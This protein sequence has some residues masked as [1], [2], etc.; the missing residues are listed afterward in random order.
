MLNQVQR[1]EGL[2]QTAK[3]TVSI[4]LYLKSDNEQYPTVLYTFLGVVLSR[5]SEVVGT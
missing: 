4:H 5:F 2:E 3:P 1:F